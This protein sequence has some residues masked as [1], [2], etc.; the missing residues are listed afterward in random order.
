MA[1]GISTAVLTKYDTLEFKWSATAS[2]V[3]NS[4]TITWELN[5]KSTAYGAIQSTA[6]KNITIT[7]G[8]SRFTY[9]N[10][11]GIA[12]NSTKKLASGGVV[13]QHLS[14]GSKTFPFSYGLDAGITFAGQYIGLVGGSGT[15]V[16]DTIQRYAY[17]T[18]YPSFNDEQNPT[19]GYLCAY[20]TTISKIE[21]CIADEN[22]YTRTAYYELSKTGT[23]YTFSL[24]DNDRERLRA[25]VTVADMSVAVKYCIR[26]TYTDNTTKLAFSP[27]VPFYLINHEPELNPTVTEN[28]YTFY[29]GN[30]STI[31]KGE[32]SCAFTV[33][34]TAKKGATIVKQSVKCGSQ[35]ID[36]MATGTLF[37]V[38]SGTFIF[39]ATDSRGATTTKEIQ[40]TL[41]DYFKPNCNLSIERAVAD[42]TNITLN[43]DGKW[44]NGSFGVM[45]NTLSVYYR[46]K[47]NDGTYST[48]QTVSNV[49]KNG[50]TY[51]GAVVVSDISYQNKYTFQMYVFDTFNSLY[52]TE[53]VIKITPIFDW[54]ESDFHFNVPVSIDGAV[55]I[56]GNALADWVVESGNDGNYAYRKWASGVAEA[57][58]VAQTIVSFDINKPYGS[59]YYTNNLTVSTTGGASCFKSVSSVQLTINKTSNVGVFQGVVIDF[60]AD[61][62]GK[63]TV[64]YLIS[65]P[66]SITSTM[67]MPCVYILGRW[68]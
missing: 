6:S 68:K 64:E 19:I 56:Q 13:M 37:D 52:S 54:G 16:L 24:T 11:I 61:S 9:T 41:V 32:N 7:I 51:S 27:L 67:A 21:A 57:W 23:S 42:D 65:N 14:D 38:D 29:T 36:N 28:N 55:T 46:Y 15:G 31:I 5:L 30:P 35:Q 66:V 4:S 48:L 63:A 44:F 39:E 62:T 49:T 3:N 34:A 18:K 45:P 58:R 22:G 1:S 59:M 40:L 50:N 60:G 2:A 53:E 47:I 26:T 33:G 10:T 25:L 8:G 17:L 20:N 12:A 43:F